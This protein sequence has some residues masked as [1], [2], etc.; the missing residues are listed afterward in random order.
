MTSVEPI[1]P[2][3]T[4]S[5][6]GRSLVLTADDFGYDPRTSALIVSLLLDGCLSA[7]TV[8]AVVEDLQDQV[9]PLLDVTRGRCGL[10]FATS[11]D[12]GPRP[13]RPLSLHGAL[14]GPDGF[15]AND[16]LVAEQRATP[17]V[18]RSELRA[19][20]SRLVTLGLTPVRLDSHSGTL[21]GFHGN[22]MLG[23]GISLCAE[24]GLG[25]RLPRSLNLLA[26]PRPSGQVRQAHSVAVAAAD[27]SGVPL[28][29]EVATDPRPFDRIRDYSDLLAH[30]VSLVRALPEGTS[31]I[32]LHPG[33]DSA[34]SRANMG[35][36]WRK[37]LWEA[38]LLEDPHWHRVIEE[39]GITLV[40]AW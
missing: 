21:Y 33:A 22:S 25:L 8:L 24:F 26:G 20:L 37:R 4:A 16:P 12:R 39:E 1:P 3:T 35:P 17:D 30:Y 36:G 6:R 40:D 18:I 15:L 31:E 23:E 7:T 14:A 11:S 5:R 32:L 13:W 29:V 2:A 38:R 19:Q 10:H 34:W 28:P 9:S 27:V